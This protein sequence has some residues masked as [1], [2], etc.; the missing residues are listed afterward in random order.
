MVY[1]RGF[2]PG[3]LLRGFLFAPDAV[4]R[5]WQLPVS[6]KTSGPV[7]A[8]VLEPPLAA[9]FVVPNDPLLFLELGGRD[10]RFR[11]VLRVTVHGQAQLL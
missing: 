9:T 2:A 4:E 3:S 11:K 10:L 5:G 6:G 8:F 7:L 1:V